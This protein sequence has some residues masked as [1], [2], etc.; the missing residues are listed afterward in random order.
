MLFEIIDNYLQYFQIG[1]A[2]LGTWYAIKRP[3]KILIYFVC[4]FWYACLNEFFATYY[5][6]HIQ[7]D[8]NAI[9]YNV[10]YLVFFG[11]LYYILGAVMQHKIA[12][13]I[14]G[15]WFA[16]Y[17]LL[18]VVETTLWELD[19]FESRQVVPY[20]F[21][22]IGVLIGVLCFYL[23]Q[24]LS[25]KVNR[26]ENKISFW[27]LTS[28]FLYLLGFVP[29]KIGQNYYASQDGFHYLLNVFFVM[30]LLTNLLL[31]IGFIWTGRKKAI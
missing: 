24:L 6:T 21:A 2:L 10:Y 3:S 8:Q 1:T 16:I 18:I 7:I 23:E 5:G 26:V 15:V 31:I 25:L 22:G 27:I 13:Y 12:K 17:I 19:Y 28:Y 14:I 20:I 29:V 4:F 9:V 30:T 11:M